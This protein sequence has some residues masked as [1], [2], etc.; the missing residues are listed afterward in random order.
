MTNEMNLEEYHIYLTLMKN[1]GMFHVNADGTKLYVLV[2]DDAELLTICGN[3]F[4]KADE[5]TLNRVIQDF[6]LDNMK[7]Q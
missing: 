4:H 1:P 5:E 3:D 2:N 6:I 7:Q